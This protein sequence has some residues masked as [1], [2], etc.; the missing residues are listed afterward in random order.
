LFYYYFDQHDKVISKSQSKLVSSTPETGRA[1]SEGTTTIPPGKRLSYCYIDQYGNI[2]F[3]KKPEFV[4]SALETDRTNSGGV[5]TILPAATYT[6]NL[7]RTSRTDDGTT[8]P[9]ASLPHITVLSNSPKSSS[10]VPM[11]EALCDASQTDPQKFINR[12]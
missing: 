8:A 5:S 11:P 4:S 6:P 9:H 2:F 7:V 3:R 10:M 12:F 1:N